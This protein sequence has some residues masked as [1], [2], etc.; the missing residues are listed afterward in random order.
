VSFAEDMRK[1]LEAARAQ[2]AM[3]MAGEVGAGLRFNGF[4]EEARPMDMIAVDGSYSFLLNIS[5]WRLAMISVAL[6]RY[7]FIEEHFAKKDWRM[8]QRVVG[9]DTFEDYVERQG[10]FYKTLFEFTRGSKEQH[11]EMVNEWRRF[12]E[13]Q[14]AVNVAEDTK[15]CIIAMDGALSTFP[16]QFDFIGRL[17]EIC[18][19]NGHLLVGVSK[20]SQLHAFGHNLT[21]E[22]LLKSAEKTLE[23]GALAFIRAPEKFEKRQKGF[24]Y[25]DVYY[26]R[27]HP[28]SGKWFRVDLG[29][30][31]EEP[32]K[33]FGQ[34]APYCR[35]L[36]AVGYPL[37]L[38][39]AHRMAVTV[40]HLRGA[41]QE[42]VMKLAVRMGMNPRLVLDGLTE[43]EGRKRSAFHE[44]LDRL[45]R[46]RR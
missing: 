4:A 16:K 5:S 46:D 15:G 27:F 7:S 45:S 35:S 39:E 43:I 32:E 3:P 24:L 37:P 22:D 34:V 11:R 28:R 23:D 44:Y 12:I 1:E 9:I 10:D 33:A 19:K 14:L 20:D 30:M 8:I 36:L 2:Y 25:G 41:Y 17:V 29:T 42:T 6:L 18:E 31:K 21:D 40:R 26:C 38:V 13:G